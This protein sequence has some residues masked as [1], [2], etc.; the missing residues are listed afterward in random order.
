MMD[1][2]SI[3]LIGSEQARDEFSLYSSVSSG[4]DVDTVWP[5]TFSYQPTSFTDCTEL[6]RSKHPHSEGP[7]Q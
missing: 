3:L 1:A 4:K 2:Y 5:F 6:A 7:H